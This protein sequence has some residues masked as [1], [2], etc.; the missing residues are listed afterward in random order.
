MNKES[1]NYCVG[2]KWPNSDALCIYTYFGEVHYGTL[3]DAE[4]FK[5]YVEKQTGE[6]SYIYILNKF[7]NE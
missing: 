2:R 1:F 7:E 3:D 5:K 6:K 4:A